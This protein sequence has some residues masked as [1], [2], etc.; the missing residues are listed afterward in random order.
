MHNIDD[1]APTQDVDERLI[2]WRHDVVSQ[3]HELPRTPLALVHCVISHRLR[4]KRRER[5]ES[6][7]DVATEGIDRLLSIADSY[8]LRASCSEP[9]ENARLRFCEVLKLIHDH[10]RVS[11]LGHAPSG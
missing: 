6:A 10:V 5:V 3:E 7:C 2:L 1:S 9:D 4:H 11:R 8:K